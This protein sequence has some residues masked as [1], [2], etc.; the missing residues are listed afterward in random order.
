MKMRNGQQKLSYRA[1]AKVLRRSPSHICRVINGER[2]A[3]AL[4][5]AACKRNGVRIGARR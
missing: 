5:L 4:L 3:G 2:K 1:L